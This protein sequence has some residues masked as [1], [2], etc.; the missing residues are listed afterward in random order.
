[1]K[2]SKKKKN[3]SDTQIQHWRRRNYRQL[4][5]D[6]IPSKPECLQEY[7]FVLFGDGV[8]VETCELQGKEPREDY[9]GRGAGDSPHETT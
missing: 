2:H 5:P 6:L 4:L 8:W 9:T 7:L 3:P 1:M